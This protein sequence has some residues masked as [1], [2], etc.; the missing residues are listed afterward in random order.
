MTSPRE[1]AAT[2]SRLEQLPCPLCGRHLERAK[3]RHGLV[4][5]CRGCRAGAV[6]L[7]V[8][9]HVAPRAFVNALWQ[10][11][12][13]AGGRSRLRCPACGQPFTELRRAGATVPLRVQVCVRCFWVW[14]GPH[15]LSAF[16][17]GG[18]ERRRLGR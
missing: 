11:A 1:S 6:T 8:V 16:V 4:W 17:A 2:V 12:L 5:L 3:G 7:P 13:R 15:L 18:E 9:R 10:E 14:L